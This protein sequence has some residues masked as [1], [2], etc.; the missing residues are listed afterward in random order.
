MA[1]DLSSLLAR[2]PEVYIDI[3]TSRMS[4]TLEDG[5]GAISAILA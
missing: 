5:R 2:V 3:T 1:Q 4:D